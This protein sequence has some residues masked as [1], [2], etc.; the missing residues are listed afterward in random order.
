MFAG[1]KEASG[2]GVVG[3]ISTSRHTD[4]D[5]ERQNT[6]V[7]S[8]EHVSLRQANSLKYLTKGLK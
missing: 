6:H 2:A 7:A 4:F 3:Q 8:N 1:S 5:N